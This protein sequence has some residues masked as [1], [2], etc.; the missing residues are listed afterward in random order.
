MRHSESRMSIPNPKW[1]NDI[2]QFTKWW[3]ADTDVIRSNE[4]NLSTGR[5]RPM[6]QTQVE[7]QDPLEIIEQIK[8]IE[9][10]IMEELEFLTDR[11]KEVGGEQEAAE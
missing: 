7:L 8:T 10:E 2:H 1:C 6:S 3:F 11:L 5:Y 9:S 4:F